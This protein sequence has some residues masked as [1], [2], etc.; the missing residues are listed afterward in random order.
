VVVGAGESFGASGTGRVTI[1][2]CLSNG[3]SAL[4]CQ[5]LVL[6]ARRGAY[7]N[8]DGKIFPAHRYICAFG[9]I[10]PGLPWNLA[11]CARFPLYY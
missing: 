2:S 8:L 6:W 5:L 10:S 3:G 9:E 1:Q 11:N 7:L 4:I